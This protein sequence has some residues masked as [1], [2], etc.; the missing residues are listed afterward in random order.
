MDF[1]KY[2]DTNLKLVSMCSISSAEFNNNG[3][4]GWTGISEFGFVIALER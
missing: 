1:V 2:L 4:V 3:K